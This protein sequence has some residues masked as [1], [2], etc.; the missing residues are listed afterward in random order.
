MAGLSQMTLFPLIN[1]QQNLNLLKQAIKNDRVANAYLFFGP[2]GSGSEGFAI[3]FAA[4]LNCQSHIG[5][6]CGS[7]SA[8]KKIKKLEYGNLELVYPIPRSSDQSSNSDPFRKFSEAD[9]KDL[10]DMIAQKAENPYVKINI[11]KARHIPISF[12]REIKRKTYLRSQESGWKVIAIFDAHLMT[13]PA[14]NAFLKILEEPPEKTTFI[15]STSNKDA[16]LPTI[17]SRC[18]SLFFPALSPKHLKEY[19]KSKN[20]PDDHIG[21]IIRLSA[22]DVTQALQIV[23][24]DLDKFVT[25][26]LEIMRAVAV[27]NIKSI[28]EFVETLA[29]I[30]REDAPQF[31]QILLS[32]SF[33]FRD[34]V[35]IKNHAETDEMVHS[36]L[37]EEISKFIKAFPDFDPHLAISSVEN[38]I[39]FINRNVYI[40]LALLNMFFN[41]HQSLNT[42]KNK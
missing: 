16:I 26:P 21:L 14:A 40:N 4:M 9:I 18:Q 31:R 7:C 17:L 33:W 24:T 15:L 30:Y 13:P 29:A 35:L 10:Q 1:Q 2:E 5:E 25:M 28:Y 27:W 3:E 23:N 32:V 42:R 37:R 22:G 34:A 39:D 6:P 38:C 19:L 12:I 36:R 41:L 20:V 8:C 11:P